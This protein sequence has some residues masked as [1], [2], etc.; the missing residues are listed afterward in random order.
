MT[1][2]CILEVESEMPN[3]WFIKQSTSSCYLAIA[4]MIEPTKQWVFQMF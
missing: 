2:Q 4:N 1:C 3:K